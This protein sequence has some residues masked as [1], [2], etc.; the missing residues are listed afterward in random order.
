MKNIVVAITVALSFVACS[1]SNMSEETIVCGEVIN[2]DSS[3]AKVLTVFPY[4]FTMNSDRL[5]M[6]ITQSDFK[7]HQKF[8]M[9]HRHD[10]AVNYNGEFYIFMAEPRD[11]IFVTIDAKSKEIIFGGSKARFNTQLDR[12]SKAV[13]AKFNKICRFDLDT[14]VEGVVAQLDE[15]MTII[16]DT[17][18]VFCVANSI[19]DGV[20][21]YLISNSLYGFANYMLMF[22]RVNDY[23]PERYRLLT[24]E[25]FD[26]Y[27]PD[28]VQS[29]MYSVHLRN[30]MGD[31]MTS[32]PELKL[33]Y[34]RTDKDITKLSQLLLKRTLELP[35]SIMRDIQLYNGVSFL[36][37]LSEYLSKSV[38]DIYDERYLDPNNY[39]NTRFLELYIRPM[40]QPTV[41]IQPISGDFDIESDVKYINSDNELESLNGINIIDFIKERYRGKVIYLDIWAT[42]CR[43]CMEEMKPA[44]DLHKMYEQRSDIAFVNLCLSS[45]VDN[46]VRSIEKN[47]IG[48][49]NYFVGSDDVAKMILSS[50][51][52]SGYPSYILIDKEGQLVTT[53]AFRP[54]QLGQLSEQLEALF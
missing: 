49:E 45:K 6:D 50:Y 7:F 29:Y 37:Y 43:P 10:V 15:K 33:E 20:R 40:L 9:T 13:D 8:S 41:D 11:S 19:D 26:I 14:D 54:S 30:S 22:D 53:S 51:K 24:H 47:T 31:F 32:D 27:N 44:K 25:I 18:E 46:W 4:D 17:L 38:D 34:E 12:A 23:S 52:L 2:A 39:S 36:N 42:W 35:K 3:S 28:H 21:D 48:G 16:K 5:A 1:L